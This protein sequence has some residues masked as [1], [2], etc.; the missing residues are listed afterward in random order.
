MLSRKHRLKKN[1][2]FN[3]IYKKGQAKHSRH[4]SV[5]FVSSKISEI[6]VGISVSKKVGKS[7][8]RSKVKRRLS[9]I[10]RLLLPNLK[11]N[12][13]YIFITK[14]GIADLSYADLKKEVVYVL[15]K[16]SLLNENND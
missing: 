2:Q 8:V 5:V 7:V 16:A 15:K 6:K 4:L 3:Y 12:T 14:E 10:V 9:E 13:N 1:T 11:Q